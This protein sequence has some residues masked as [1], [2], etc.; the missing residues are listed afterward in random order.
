MALC[1]WYYLDVDGVVQ[2]TVEEWE[3]VWRWCFDVWVQ[4]TVPMIF[5]SSAISKKAVLI[6]SVSSVQKQYVL[7]HEWY[8][9]FRYSRK[10]TAQRR[11]WN[12]WSV[13]YLSLWKDPVAKTLL[14]T[15]RCGGTWFHPLVMPLSVW[16]WRTR[17]ST[18]SNIT[19]NGSTLNLVEILMHN[20]NPLKRMF[21][22]IGQA[23]CGNDVFFYL[24]TTRK[25]F[26]YLRE[27]QK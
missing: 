15:C 10:R 17:L 25:M 14:S 2:F 4:S 11:L 5:G 3:W 18:N 16:Y 24:L 20:S 21:P 6:S 13:S 1:I 19:V 22:C 23:I 27:E 26:F 7:G 12:D 8:D 9:S